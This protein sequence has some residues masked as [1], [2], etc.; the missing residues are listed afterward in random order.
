M[1]LLAIIALVLACMLALFAIMFFV[2]SACAA[3]IS[4][5]ERFGVTTA[6]LCIA[7][8]VAYGSLAVLVGGAS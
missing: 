8:A 3:Y 7:A 1:Q 4:V 2:K 5:V 6:L